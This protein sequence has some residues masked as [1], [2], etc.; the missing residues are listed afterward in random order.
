MQPEIGGICIYKGFQGIFPL[1]RGMSCLSC[2]SGKFPRNLNHSPA[3]WKK[4]RLKGS[5][6]GQHGEKLPGE[7][8][9]TV[10]KVMTWL[11]FWNGSSSRMAD[12]GK[13]QLRNVNR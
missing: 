9:N 7:R 12:T 13:V 10:K 6:P 11:F 3:V 4:A 2:V 5:V 8:K 1:T